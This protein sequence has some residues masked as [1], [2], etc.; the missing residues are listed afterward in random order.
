MPTPPPGKLS[1]LADNIQA[2]AKSLSGSVDEVV[3]SGGKLRDMN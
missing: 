2:F 1:G 3:E